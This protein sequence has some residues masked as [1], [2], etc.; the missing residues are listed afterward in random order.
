[1]LPLPSRTNATNLSD[2]E[3]IL[4][5]VMFD[6]GAAWNQLR[7]CN[8]HNQW[9]YP[10]HTLDDNLLRETLSLLVAAGML[11]T[12]EF[13]G[14][15]YYHV[16]PKGGSLW[17]KERL[18]VWER[19]ATDCYS[20]IGGKAAVTIVASRPDTRDDFW[21]LGCQSGMFPYSCGRIRIGKLRR[22]NTLVSWRSFKEFHY[23]CAFLEDGETGYDVVP[24]IDQLTFEQERTWWRR[25]GENEKFLGPGATT[26]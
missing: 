8:F 3:L 4:F 19:F 2:D 20:Q 10:A 22:F 7:R 5:D 16:T 17:E 12:N 18:P 6:G 15:T 24:Q 25:I 13:R 26:T 9:A 1:M 14:H 11:S 21:R 23:L